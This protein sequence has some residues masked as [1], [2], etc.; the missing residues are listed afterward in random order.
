MLQST[1]NEL[2]LPRTDAGGGVQAIVV[3]LLMVTVAVL[4]RRERSLVTL[5]IGIGMVVLGVMG[6]RTLH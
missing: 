6:L 3:I 2:L 5:T 1:A 4:L